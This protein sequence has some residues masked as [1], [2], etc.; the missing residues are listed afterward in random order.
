MM[1][2]ASI[3]KLYTHRVHEMARDVDVNFGSAELARVCNS[4][5]ALAERWGAPAGRLIARRLCDLAAVD[6]VALDRLPEARVE[7]T[8]S[9][10]LRVSFG[11]TMTIH[12]VLTP[13]GPTSVSPA[14]GQGLLITSVNIKGTD[15]R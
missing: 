12:G 10:L 1:Y 6:L 9:G 8:T 7:T 2:L 3:S 14:N 4:E 13:A 11:E 15:V 5:E